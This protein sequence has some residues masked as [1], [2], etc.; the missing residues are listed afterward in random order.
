VHS[1]SGA[2]SD[3]D[4]LRFKPQAAHKTDSRLKRLLRRG[5]AP[6]VCFPPGPAAVGFEL[7]AADVPS[8]RISEYLEILRFDR[9]NRGIIKL[10]DGWILK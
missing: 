5:R 2:G 7:M 4:R 9:H 10:R 8:V 3:D 1:E 6:S